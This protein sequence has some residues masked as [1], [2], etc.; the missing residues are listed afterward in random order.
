[1]APEPV[2]VLIRNGTILTVDGERRIL[3]DG[4]VAVRGDRIVAVGKTADLDAAYTADK[5]IDASQKLV[6][7]GLS[8]A[9][10]I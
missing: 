4:A 7:P 9:T 1:M 5:T 3:T 10:P 6:M 2:D 8:T